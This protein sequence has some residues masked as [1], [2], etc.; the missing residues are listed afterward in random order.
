[1]I[2]DV[3]LITKEVERDFRIWHSDIERFKLPAEGWTESL[4]QPCKSK[5]VP[6][7]Q[8]I[9]KWLDPPCLPF[10]QEHIKVQPGSPL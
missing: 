5:V 2:F 4:W 9:Q 7:A 6:E 1:M 10:L 3:A 8:E